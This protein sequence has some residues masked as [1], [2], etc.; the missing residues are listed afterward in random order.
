MAW[1]YQDSLGP[2]WSEVRWL[3]MTYLGPRHDLLF[4]SPLNGNQR[5]FKGV[6]HFQRWKEL[7]NCANFHTF[8]IWS[9]TENVRF[10]GLESRSKTDFP[11]WPALQGMQMDSTTS[12]QMLRWKLNLIWFYCDS[13]IYAICWSLGFKR[14]QGFSSRGLVQA[15][16]KKVVKNLQKSRFKMFL[17]GKPRSQPCHTRCLLLDNKPPSFPKRPKQQRDWTWFSGLATS[18]GSLVSWLSRAIG[19]ACWGEPRTTCFEGPKEGCGQSIS[20]ACNE[21]YLFTTSWY[22]LE[23]IKQKSSRFQFQSLDQKLRGIKHG[24]TCRLFHKS[25]SPEDPAVF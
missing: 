7:N 11:W 6:V 4:I 1:A 3:A 16:Q 8:H 2:N 25:P 19:L 12:P 24:K 17:P 22:L 5:F 18:A 20:K 15:Q 21:T 9:A 14:I 13:S 23:K 10:P